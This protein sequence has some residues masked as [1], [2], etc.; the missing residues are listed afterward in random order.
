MAQPSSRSELIDY[1]LRQ[2]GAPVLE[3]NV[4]NEQLQDLMDDAI[5]FYQERHYDGVT[6]NFLKY[7]VTQGDIDRGKAKI[8]SNPVTGPG[9]SS[10]TASSV[11]AGVGTVTYKYYESSNYIQIPPNV[12]GVKKVFKVNSTRAMGMSGNMFSFK[13]QLVLNDLYFWGRTELLGYSMAMS[14]LETMDFLLNTHTRVRFNIRQDRLYLDI[15]WGE[16]VADDVLIIECYTALDPDA[17]TKVYNDRFL[18]KY[19][20]ALIKKQWGQNLIKFKGTKLPGGIE[21]NGREL[22]DD[23]VS[24]LSEIK[25]RMTLEYEVPPLD[26][27]G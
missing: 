10:T 7:K 21:L 11:V 15:D 12:I 25:E 22:Y 16:V 9:I 8:D 20:T 6:D 14:Y 3:I 26:M 24:E 2:L 27:I 1:S 23:A 18:K 5:Q 4:A 17:S 13:Y 19:L